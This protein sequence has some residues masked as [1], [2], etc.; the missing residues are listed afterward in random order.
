M[1]DYAKMSSER[2][3]ARVDTALRLHPRSVPGI[4]LTT[5]SIPFPF[6]GTNVVIPIE[7]VVS[8][9]GAKTA[10]DM[11]RLT[12]A[13]RHG[14]LAAMGGTSVSLKVSADGYAIVEPG[15]QTMV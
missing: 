9:A 6:A 15:F 13:Y 2:H 14:R 7:D 8:S 5:A 3:Y 1:N 11:T 12:V 10:I 4:V